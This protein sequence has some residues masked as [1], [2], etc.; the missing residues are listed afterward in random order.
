MTEFKFED[1]KTKVL[2]P[3]ELF[4]M[5]KQATYDSVVY[6]PYCEYSNLEAD[7]DNCPECGRFNP[8]KENGFSVVKSLLNFSK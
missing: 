5:L 6:C 8:L 3:K 2:T 7:Y 1:P 4:Q